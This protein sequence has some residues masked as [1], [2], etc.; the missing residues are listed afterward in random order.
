MG[1][2]ETVLLIAADGFT[3]RITADG[4]A[5]YGHRVLLAKDGRE[6]LDILQADPGLVGMLVADAEL[7]DGLGVA[8]MARLLDPAIGVILTA[9]SPGSVPERGRVRGALLLRSPYGTSE[10]VAAIDGLRGAASAD[11]ARR[12]A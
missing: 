8:R 6:A 12:A 3:R 4:L 1:G 2:P 10:I 7:G 11:P 9:R 5:M